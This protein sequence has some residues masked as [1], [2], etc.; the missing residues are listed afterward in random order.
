[1]SIGNVSKGKF[2]K[3]SIVRVLVSF[4]SSF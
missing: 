4:D 1:M 3:Q 2:E